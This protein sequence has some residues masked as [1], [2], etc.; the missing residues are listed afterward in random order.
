VKLGLFVSTE[1]NLHHLVG[2]TQEAVSRGHEVK[3]FVMDDG[4]HLLPHELIAGLSEIESVD[5][6]YCDL[7]AK[8]RGIDGSDLSPGLKSGSQ[9]DNAGMLSEVDKLI[10]L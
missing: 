6:S 8:Q 5:I 7:N 3:I 9:N 1:G 4:A 2:I 10:C